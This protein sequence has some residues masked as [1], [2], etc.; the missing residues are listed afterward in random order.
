MR[1]ADDVTET[2][3]SLQ[4][5]VDS[6][7]GVDVSVD[8]T[9]SSCKHLVPTPL[10]D[11]ARRLIQAGEYEKVTIPSMCERGQVTLYDTSLF[12]DS[13]AQSVAAMNAAPAPLPTT[14]GTDAAWRTV[15]TYCRQWYDRQMTDE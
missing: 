6:S 5:D 11:K 12:E 9:K 14:L 3:L 13:S 4:F 10:I 2:T 8:D 15:C 1:D 7:A